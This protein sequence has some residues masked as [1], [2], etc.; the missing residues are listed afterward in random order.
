V[1]KPTYAQDDAL[2]HKKEENHTITHMD[3]IL[4]T[5][6][7]A[8]R[9]KRFKPDLSLVEAQDV[10]VSCEQTRGGVK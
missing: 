6:H 8:Q 7:I 2:D 5:D 3:N 9:T 4:M 1:R 10:P